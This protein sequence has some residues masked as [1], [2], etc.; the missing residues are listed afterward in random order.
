M[1]FDLCTPDL[2]SF[3]Q[4][5]EPNWLWIICRFGRGL[6]SKSKL[7]FMLEVNNPKARASLILKSAIE[8]F[9]KAEHKI[10]LEEHEEKKLDLEE[11]KT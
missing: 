8:P 10:R 6:G 1:T 11:N 7:D 5:K 9:S 2:D 4:D 3:W